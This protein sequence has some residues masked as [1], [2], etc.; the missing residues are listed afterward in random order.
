MLLTD[1]SIGRLIS[2]AVE[3]VR[4]IIAHE[5]ALAKAEISRAAKA[6]GIGAGL[7]AAALSL[8]GLGSIFLLIAGAEALVAAGLS[9]WAAFLIVGGVLVLLAVVLALVGVSLLKK[10]KGPQ[11]TI[12][13]SKAV[14]ADVKESLAAVKPD[15]ATRQTAMT[16]VVTASRSTDVAGRHG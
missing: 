15:P 1:R 5:K 13:S 14:V 2:D 8:L 11:R 3:D 7:L 6:G 16:T 10:V 12:T 9:R 4:V